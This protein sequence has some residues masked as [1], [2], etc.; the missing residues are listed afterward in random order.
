MALS[1][2]GYG[3]H[4]APVDFPDILDASAD[5]F[6][7]MRFEDGRSDIDEVV[8]LPALPPDRQRGG[9]TTKP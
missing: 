8:G 7:T 5:P 6:A 3:A 9:A 1:T 4:G 2:R